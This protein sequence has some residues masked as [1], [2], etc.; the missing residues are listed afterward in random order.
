[1]LLRNVDAKIGNQETQRCVRGI[2][3]DDQVEWAPEMQGWL[4]VRKPLNAIASDHRVQ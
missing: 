4:N 3:R 2:K 1:M